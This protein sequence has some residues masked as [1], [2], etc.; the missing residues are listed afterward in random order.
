MRPAL[1]HGK[2][3]DVPPALGISGAGGLPSFLPFEHSHPSAEVKSLGE[4]SPSSWVSL[5]DTDDL[6]QTHFPPNIFNGTDMLDFLHLLVQPS[7]SLLL[8]PT[9]YLGVDTCRPHPM[10]SLVLCPPPS[11]AHEKHQKAVRG[12]EERGSS[13]PCFPNFLFGHRLAVAFSP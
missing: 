13:G 6:S 10:C 2:G 11:S 4:I 8:C 5:S 1:T 7:L 12:E 3:T 9:P